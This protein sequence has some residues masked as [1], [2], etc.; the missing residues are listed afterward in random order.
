MVFIFIILNIKQSR[1]IWVQF[2]VLD[3]VVNYVFYFDLV[4]YIYCVSLYVWEL[5]R[6][7]EFGDGFVVFLMDRYG[8]GE[9]E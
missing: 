7:D 1:K 2:V 4:F 5:G 6:L 9:D 3:I 8:D